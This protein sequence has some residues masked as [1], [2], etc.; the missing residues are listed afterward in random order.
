VVMAD[1]Q[2][3]FAFLYEDSQAQAIEIMRESFHPSFGGK[4]WR[5]APVLH[6]SKTPSV[7]GPF[8]EFG[9]HTRSILAELGYSEDEIQKLAAD[10]VV[11]LGD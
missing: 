2:S 9:E 6:F 3:H 7:G 1:A 4:Y 5:Y 8:C 10:G 11:A